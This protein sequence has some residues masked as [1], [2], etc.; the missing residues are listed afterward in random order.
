[1]TKHSSS[2][3]AL[4]LA[5]TASSCVGDLYEDMSA[6]PIEEGGEGGSGERPESVEN[7]PPGSIS[8]DGELPPLITAAEP[9][10]V[11]ATIIVAEEHG[12]DVDDA[13]LVLAVDAQLNGMVSDLLGG[14]AIAIP[15]EGLE[16]NLVDVEPFMET[17]YVGITFE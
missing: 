16:L 17:N 4:V 2:A 7:V 15:L 8:I 5:V 14:V 11:E 13:M 3:I 6:L 1:M 12:V 9:G 10:N